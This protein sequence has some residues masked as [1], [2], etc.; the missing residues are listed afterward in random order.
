MNSWLSLFTGFQSQQMTWTPFN[1]LL[2]ITSLT[3]KVGTSLALLG[4]HLKL[5]PLPEDLKTYYII[6]PKIDDFHVGIV[7]STIEE[8]VHMRLNLTLLSRRYGDFGSL[9]SGENHLPDRLVR[10]AEKLVERFK[11]HR[12]LCNQRI[13]CLLLKTHLSSE[14]WKGTTESVGFRVTLAN[15][16][17]EALNFSERPNHFDLVVSD[18][19]MPVMDGY[20][21]V[22]HMKADSSLQRIPVVLTS[23]SEEEHREKALDRI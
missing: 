11:S 20:E 13:V 9:E 18:I 14:I 6:V 23:F 3:L 7:A 19:V 1:Q 16:G 21:L 2:K 15:N 17:S 8:S 5:K 4:Q 22:K 10:L 12:K